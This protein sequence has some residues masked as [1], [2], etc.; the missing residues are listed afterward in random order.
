TWKVTFA[1]IFYSKDSR[2]SI[3]RV[4][5]APS[6]D[7]RA[8]HDL[9]PWGDKQ[10]HTNLGR[11]SEKRVSGGFLGLGWSV[12]IPLCARCVYCANNRRNVA[13]CTDC[14]L[15]H[16]SAPVASS[17]TGRS[18]RAGRGGLSS[19]PRDGQRTYV[20]GGDRHDK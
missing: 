7:G 17:E 11:F 5:F 9:A 13:V 19:P 18:R 15:Q 4:Y 6:I 8:S 20:P 1:T 2:Q 10:C 12:C 16:A 3:H 14:I